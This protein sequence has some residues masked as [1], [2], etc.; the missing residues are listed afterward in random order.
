MRARNSK[1]LLFPK[2]PASAPAVNLNASVACLF[3]RANILN[4]DSGLAR[5]IEIAVFLLSLH[6]RLD[7]PL[8][9]L[10]ERIV[11]QTREL[12]RSFSYLPFRFFGEA[13]RN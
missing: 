7:N 11:P 5:A 12:I 3:T 8:L 9:H 6:K 13:F 2:Q 1:G 4:N 10:I